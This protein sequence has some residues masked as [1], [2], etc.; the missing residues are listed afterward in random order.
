MNNGTRSE[1]NGQAN[2]RGGEQRCFL[3]L[4]AGHAR[5]GPFAILLEVLGRADVGAVQRTQDLEDTAQDLV[6]LEVV[7]VTEAPRN[8]R[9]SRRRGRRGGEGGRSTTRT[10]R[11][12]TKTAGKQGWHNKGLTA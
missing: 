12:A 7:D 5:T 1:N 4:L 2:G 9:T 3:L 10:M 11:R 8:M 6:G